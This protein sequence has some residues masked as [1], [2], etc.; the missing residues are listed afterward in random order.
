MRADKLIRRLSIPIPM[1]VKSIESTNRP[2]STLYATYYKI[3]WNVSPR[4]P[5]K[6]DRD[7]GYARCQHAVVEATLTRVDERA[8]LGVA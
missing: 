1:T 4:V 5:S 8:C 2:T 6:M 3:S 7:T